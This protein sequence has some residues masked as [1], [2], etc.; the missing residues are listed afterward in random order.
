MS[1]SAS[2]LHAP[3]E[4]RAVGADDWRPSATLATSPAGREEHRLARRVALASLLLFVA[5]SPW[6]RLP[7]AQVWAFIPIYESALI[8]VDLITVVMLL[9]QF[10]IARSRAL[11]ML[12]C[13]YLF[14]AAATVAHALTFPGLFA[15]GGLLG[16]GPQSTAW[17]YMFW[18][19][20]F[21]LCAMAYV[22]VRGSRFEPV[23][24]AHRTRAA[25]IAG[26]AALGAAAG[27]S[28]LATA[29]QQLLPPIMQGHRYTPAMIVVVSSVWLSSLVAL[30]LLLVRRRPYT[31]LDLWLAVTLCA[32]LF[33][34]ALAAVL[35]AGRFDLGFYAGR[36]YGLLAAS[37]V[38]G[39][40]LLE[41]SAL[42][43][44]LASAHATQQR[45]SRELDQL[46]RQLQATN[47]LLSESNRRLEEQSRFKSEFLAKMSHE[48]RTPL[49]AIIGFSELLKGGM[50]GDATETQRVFAGH[51]FESGHHLLAL[52][53][54]ILDL[55]KIEAGKLETVFESVA[56][57]SVLAE[58]T[59]MVSGMAQARG[60]ALKL[61][62]R[63]S[64][65][66]FQADRRQLKQ[67]VLNLLSNAIKFSPDGA[68]VTLSVDVVERAHA[69]TALPGFHGGLRM[70]LPPSDFRHF[71]E[72][73]V[74]DTGIGI[75]GDD[76]GKLFKPF[77]Q[78]SNAVTRKAGGTGL[79]LVMVQRLVEL[80]GGAV[81]VTSEPGRGCCFTAWLPWRRDGAP[82]T[83]AAPEMASAEQDRPLA[84]VIEDNAETAFLMTAQLQTLGFAVRQV[85]SAEEALALPSELTP[86]LIT[87]DI[88]LPG[89]DGWE[90]LARRKDIPRWENV[91]VVVVSVAADQGKGFSL[92]ASFVLQK[93]V[94]WDAFAMGLKRLELV[95]GDERDVTVLVIDDD[96]S[97]VELLA[98]QLLQRNYIVLR[99]LG[100]REGVELARRFHP[101]LIVLDLEMPEVSGFDV[102]EA[103]KQ[104]SSTAHVPI[105]AVTA[106]DL[107]T[108]D[109]DRLSGHV[110][111]LVGK[112]AFNPAS[113]AGEVQRALAK[114]V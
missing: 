51:I 38:L 34:I 88:Q 8:L 15:P 98:T 21:P 80:H 13:G 11:L 81:A 48:L 58:T 100:G 113:F 41:N 3:S 74:S 99:A 44:R 12:A 78:V 97:A 42:Y 10:W 16:A 83:E 23:R 85:R 82:A 57:E 27:F 73:S 39:R 32:W 28:V 103:L 84:L 102:V 7:L 69:E 36:V 60:V 75:G 31:V 63:A 66:V 77:S 107:S 29:G 2:S 40:L 70:P 64:P 109:R 92:G 52:I 76:I 45:R 65:G 106:R 54:D 5:A 111:E 26:L 89:M 101:H 53:N 86:A 59:A 43:A 93:P 24:S 61:D 4:E 79:G 110:L 87:L 114:P 50:A 33:D 55:S 17:I 67:V 25:L 68:R 18:H 112:S 108:A 22:L 1:S 6:A 91:P 105:V 49:N 104:D 71:V 62:L 72:I 46:A 37:F 30:G 20:G 19:G 90:F 14:T 95:P 47:S 56:L 96:P 94:A 35:N 9:G